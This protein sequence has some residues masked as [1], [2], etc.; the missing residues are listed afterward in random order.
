ML[1]LLPAFYGLLVL[2]VFALAHRSRSADA[3]GAAGVLV[4]LWLMTNLCQAFVHAPYNQFYPILDGCSG[5][6]LLWYWRNSLNTWKIGLLLLLLAD[7][8]VHLD[9]FTTGDTSQQARYIYDLKLNL[10]LIMQSLT[11]AY[12]AH[13]ARR[14][15][16]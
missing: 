14:A 5:I 11:V 2:S 15:P 9:Y 8:W 12:A 6:A 4:F 7:T 3:T 16:Q 10:L 1:L 13:I